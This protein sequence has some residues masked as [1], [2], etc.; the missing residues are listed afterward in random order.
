MPLLVDKHTACEL[1]G[2]ISVD[3]LERHVLPHEEDCRLSISRRTHN[4]QPDAKHDDCR[5]QHDEYPL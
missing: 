4:H 5:S 3:T 2:G 1:L